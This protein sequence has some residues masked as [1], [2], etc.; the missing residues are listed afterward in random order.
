MKQ[1]NWPN[2]VRLA[3][4]L[5]LMLEGGGLPDL[6]TKA[7][8]A[9]RHYEGI[10]RALALMD[11]RGIKLSSF[12]IGRSV[13]TSSDLA[14]EIVRRGREAAAHGRSWENS[15]QLPREEEKRFVVDSA[16]TIHRMAGANPVGWNAYPAKV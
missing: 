12:M 7:F 8:V 3:V 5:S 6:P 9:R 13:E 10:P 11:K 16:E 1:T 14:Q 4:R 2:G 15:Y